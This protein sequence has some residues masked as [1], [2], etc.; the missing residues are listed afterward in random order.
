MDTGSVVSRNVPAIDRQSTAA[1]TKVRL[2]ISR[3]DDCVRDT[4]ATTAE[5]RNA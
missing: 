3:R 5:E 1:Q 2:V 4:A